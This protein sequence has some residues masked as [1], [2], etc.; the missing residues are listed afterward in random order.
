MSIISNTV[1]FFHLSESKVIL[2]KTLSSQCGKL[3][4]VVLLYF[5]FAFLYTRDAFSQISC[6]ENTLIG[7]DLI[8]VDAVTRN[9]QL[10]INAY[11]SKPFGGIVMP[12]TERQFDFFI[13]AD[14]NRDTG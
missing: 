6:S 9:N 14:Q 5:M 13:D 1:A 7:N 10:L 11:V 12:G 4:V 2:R 8:G 3:C